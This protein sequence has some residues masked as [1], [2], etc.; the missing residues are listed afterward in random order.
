VCC[1]HFAHTASDCGSARTESSAWAAA[2]EP[3][4]RRLLH[5]SRTLGDNF[6]SIGGD[7]VVPL[8]V[9]AMPYPDTNHLLAV[10][11]DVPSAA[12]LPAFVETTQPI[13][14]SISLPAQYIPN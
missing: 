1:S 10:F 2:A 11:G 13:V 8:Y 4:L 3:A 14:D 5:R 6:L 9:A 7:E 12:E